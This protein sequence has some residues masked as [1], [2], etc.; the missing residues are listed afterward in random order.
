MSGSVLRN[1]NLAWREIDGEIVIISPQDSQVHELNESASLIWKHAD[2]TETLE[3]IARDM[4]SEFEVGL[5]AARMDV[6]DLV[7]LLREK[8]LL[9]DSEQVKG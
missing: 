2:G 1:P 6:N 8:Q 9:L 3:Q 4:A 7:V 5:D